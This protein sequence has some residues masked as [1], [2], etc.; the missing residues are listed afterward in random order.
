MPDDNDRTYEMLVRLDVKVDNLC[1]QVAGI[2]AIQ[3]HQQQEIN[4]I[5]AV[6][7]P[8]GRKIHTLWFIGGA[9]ILGAIAWVFRLLPVK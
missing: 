9:M 3:D 8:D 1:V 6:L 5:K 7:S 2:K 4:D